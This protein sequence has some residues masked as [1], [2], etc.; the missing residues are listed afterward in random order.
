MPERRVST[1]TRFLFGAVHPM[2]V[3]D[4]AR[5]GAF[6]PQILTFA[7]M[8][9]IAGVADYTLMI[10]LRELFGVDAVAAALAGYTLGS[11]VSYLLNRMNTF[12][13]RRSH[14]AASWRFVVVNVIGFC[15]TAALMALLVN[16]LELNYVLARIVTTAAVFV[17][18]FSSHRFWTFGSVEADV[19]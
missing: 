18:N 1:A 16:L 8:G 12:R 15:L 6:V 4:R 5:S 10:S 9:A 17:L 11:V 7:A 19:K 2:R 3:R 13:S 14:A